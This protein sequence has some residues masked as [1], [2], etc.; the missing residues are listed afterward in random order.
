ME[1]LINIV[2]ERLNVD[3]KQIVISNPRKSLEVKKITIRPLEL[4][5]EICYQ[6]TSY[7]GKQVRHE[8]V[9]LDQVIEKLSIWMEQYKQ[10]QL[11]H[12]EETITALVNKKGKVSISR[13]GIKTVVPVNLSHNRT[14]QYLLQ[15]GIPVPFL[16]DLGVMQSDGT[17]IRKKYDKFRQI[18]RFLE[19]V[20]DVEPSLPQNKKLTILDFGCGKSYLTFAM[21]YYLHELRKKEVT[22][23]GLDL[24]EDV[25]AHCNDLAKKYG[26]QDLRFLTGDIKDYEDV[27]A[28]DMVVTLHAC[29]T[30]TDYALFK[31]V[32]WGASV[33]L[34]VPCCQHEL[35][36]V[37]ENDTLSPMLSYG[38]IKERFSA[39]A[40][41]AMRADLLCQVGYDAQI[42]EF[43]DMEHTPKNLLIR[44]VKKAEGMARRT[45]NKEY[46]QFR[47]FI[48]SQL[49]LEKLL[50]N[51]LEGTKVNRVKNEAKEETTCE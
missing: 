38:I 29:D 45:K 7:V 16:I 39:L 27:D 2:K 36:A 17:I 50:S 47:S 13:K 21:Y 9:A 25:I 48:G 24:K 10:L 30:A 51:D 40:T 46:E 1:Q 11:I 28:V 49:T 15:E 42:L 44:A 37:I 4:K 22:M 19:F 3:C 41:D 12:K 8:N 5:G 26:Y 14:K 35:N 6:V 32:N 20:R 34:S 23:I 33:I 18:N 31:A 43:I